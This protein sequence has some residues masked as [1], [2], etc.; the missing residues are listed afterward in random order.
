[1]FAFLFEQF[2]D[3]IHEILKLFNLRL[4]LNNAN[5]VHLL[6]YN[7]ELNNLVNPAV[8]C[9]GEGGLCGDTHVSCHHF[10]LHPLVTMIH[11]FDHVN[12]LLSDCS[13]VELLKTLQKVSFL[14]LG[15]DFL[16]HF[17]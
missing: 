4:D 15:F 8:H 7:N 10:L 11:L 9:K 1:M 16:P 6:H 14:Y 13:Y 2:Y 12:V 17:D 5:L 3:G